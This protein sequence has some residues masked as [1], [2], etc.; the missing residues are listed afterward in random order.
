[1]GCNL[2]PAGAQARPGR[3]R[4]STHTPLPRISGRLLQPC[5][6]RACTTGRPVIRA[7]AESGTAG[8]T[9]HSDHLA[10]RR[11]TAAEQAAAA[12]AEPGNTGNYLIPTT[13]LPPSSPLESSGADYLWSK[14][15]QG[16]ERRGR[17]SWA[18]NK[19]RERACVCV[20]VHT[21]GRSLVTAALD[22]QRAL[23]STPLHPPEPRI[24]RRP[25]ISK[26]LP[27]IF[28]GS[29]CGEIRERA[30]PRALLQI[31]PSPLSAPSLARRRPS[32]AISVAHTHKTTPSISTCAV[33]SE[34][35][36]SSSSSGGGGG[37]KL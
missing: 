2:W 9:E 3:E 13:P 30:T 14:G 29:V 23:P 35:T 6:R 21:F 20:G 24:S 19:C 36:S 4:E 12:A 22:L 27:V 8:S 18:S 5:G 34:P 11:A 1:V 25:L 16:G 32:S 37:D 7:G 17:Y 28:L 33:C 10:Q 26:H 15:S 31:V